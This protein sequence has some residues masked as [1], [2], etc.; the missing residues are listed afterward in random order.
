MRMVFPLAAGLALAALVALPRL[1]PTPAEVAAHAASTEIRVADSAALSRA[2]STAAPGSVIRLAP[3]D[4]ATLKI[5]REVDGAPIRITGPRSARISQANFRP[6]AGNWH[7]DGVTLQAASPRVAGLF[8]QG[9]HH[10]TVS[11]VAIVGSPEAWAMKLES[12]YGVIIRNAEAVV[13]AGS[14]MKNVRVLIG[15]IDSRGVVLEGNRLIDSREG[16]NV[17]NVHGLA[18]RHNEMSGFRPRF[19]LGEH[20]DFVQFWTRLTPT[21]SSKVE[22][23][24][25][26][27]SAGGKQPVQGVFARAE[28]YENGR[29]PRGWHRDF[30]VRQNIYYGAAR[31]GLSFSDVRGLVIENN[32]VM[33][34]PHAFTT[35]KGPRDPTGETFGGLTPSILTRNSSYGIV[36]NNVVTLFQ[37]IGDKDKS[38]ITNNFENKPRAPADARNPGNSFAQ[39]LVAETLPLTAF[40]IRPQ[41]DAGR[42]GMGADISKVGPAA[43]NRDIAALAREADALARATEAEAAGLKIQQSF[44]D[45][46]R[47]RLS[48]T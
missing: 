7:L 3:G 15:L 1:L 46:V 14:E 16:I 41:S 43:A 42:K 17:S 44:M 36:R 18:V 13:V 6:G 28:D 32:T 34:S 29:S 35:V 37:L 8:V 38:T 45:K 19:D 23:I 22:V 10:V 5:E 24:G 39:P 27:L 21:G 31:N 9:A 48:A 4:Y 30:V 25:N 11:D 33:A 26:F 2:I 20:P 47:S 40:A 12:G